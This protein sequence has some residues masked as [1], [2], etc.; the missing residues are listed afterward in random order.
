MTEGRR[1]ANCDNADG[2]I[3]I[4]KI[5]KYHPISTIQAFED[6][7]TVGNKTAICYN[8]KNFFLHCK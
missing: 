8:S 6:W 4:Q 5:Y 2:K 7:F 3:S 1:A